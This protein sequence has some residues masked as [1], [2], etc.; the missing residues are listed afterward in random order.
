MPRVP[1]V[2]AFAGTRGATSAVIGRSRVRQNAES[3]DGRYR[4]CSCVRQNAESDDGR[5]RS[6]L[7]L[8]E[9]GERR[10]P[11]SA[12]VL[13]QCLFVK[14]FY[15]EAVTSQSPGLRGFASYPGFVVALFFYREAVALIEATLSG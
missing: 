6:Y 7:R 1:A 15:R 8:P 14:D 12:V 5:H 4:S 13:Q 9:R 3:D 11:S 10:D 2:A